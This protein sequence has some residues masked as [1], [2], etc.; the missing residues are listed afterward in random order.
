MRLLPLLLGASLALGA[1]GEVAG[2]G[3]SELQVYRLW[4]KMSGPP[5]VTVKVADGDEIDT[6]LD[7]IEAEIRM[8][9]NTHPHA[10]DWEAAVVSIV[11]RE[12]SEI[13]FV[14]DLPENRKVFVLCGTESYFFPTD[15]VGEVFK[16][17]LP[18]STRE[19]DVKVLSNTPQLLQVDNFLSPEECDQIINSAKP[20]MKRS[21]VEVLDEGGKTK[22][23]VDRTSTTSWL[24][25]KDCPF[26]KTLHERVEDL[27]KVPKSYA[28]TLQV[29]HYAPGQ[30]YKV[31]HDYITVYNDQPRYAEGHNRMITVFFY[32]TTVEEGGETIFPYGSM[33]PEEHDKVRN[34]G[35]CDDAVEPA[36]RVPARKGNAIIFYHTTP[37]GQHENSF[38]VHDKTS[39]HGGCAPVKGD[40]WAANF[41]IRN[42]P[43]RLGDYRPH[44]RRRSPQAKI[45]G[46]GV[47]FSWPMHHHLD[48]ARQRMLP[49]Q[50]KEYEKFLQGCRDRYPR[51]DLCMNTENQR[52]SL[53]LDQPAQSLNYTRLGFAKRRVPDSVWPQI[54]EFWKAIQDKDSVE[55]WNEGNTF[56]NHWAS[57]TYMAN[58]E[59]QRFPGGVALKQKIL[60]EIKP[61]LERWTGLRLKH[62]S[63]YGVRVYKT[64]SILA[65]HVDRDP[66]VTSA[67]INVAQDVDEDWPLEVVGHDGNAYNI[68]MKAGDLVLYES[69]SL[70]HGRPFP[71][72]GRYFANIF[73]H[74]Q[75]YTPYN[76]AGVAATDDNRGKAKFKV[77]DISKGKE[78]TLAKNPGQSD[79]HYAAAIGDVSILQGHEDVEE[80][81]ELAS[82][83]DVNDWQPMHEAARGGHLEA[84]K[85]LHER[86]GA[87]LSDRTSGGKG[88]S[89]LRL[90]K[91]Y[92]G[93]NAAITKWLEQMGAPDHDSEL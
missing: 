93:D 72:K 9:D 27:V 1:S 52:V 20:G 49:S 23:H 5:H 70:I 67:I 43:F 77:V 32:L 11:T 55:V 73:L 80:G 8:H 45:R 16:V 29:L 39:L 81:K 24:Y 2:T 12:G 53:L 15:V 84:A 26:V 64:D 35:S 19:V 60:D 71:M 10:G 59:D 86:Y 87:S 18:H 47:D 75:P 30:L 74:F 89:P 85:V 54:Q 25:D 42:G 91:M 38:L 78:S 92:Q 17:Q 82:A 6:V 66:L 22:E 61:I 68:T 50:S 88:W 58:L 40:K 51:G 63:T 83:K 4:E 44:M 69:H 13:E 90:A 14:N 76:V 62:V 34:W 56:T 41:W 7:R 46:V 3:V 21:T 57:P 28:E 37:K 79:F 65:P 36:L 33:P 31:H 48:G